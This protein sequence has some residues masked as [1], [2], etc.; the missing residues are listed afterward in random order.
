MR[1]RNYH[2]NHDLRKGDIVRVARWEDGLIERLEMYYKA[3]PYKIDEEEFIVC[4]IDHNMRNIGIIPKNSRMRQIIAR[5]ELD[6]ANLIRV[7]RLS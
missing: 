4:V 1:L 2:V 3:K 6:N 5:I 7:G